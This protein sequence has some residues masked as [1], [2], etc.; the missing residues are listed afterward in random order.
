MGSILVFS[1]VSTPLSPNNKY[2]CVWG[3]SQLCFLEL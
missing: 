3:H 2:V 1:P